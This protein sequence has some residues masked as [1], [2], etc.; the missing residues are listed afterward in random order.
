MSNTLSFT[1]KFTTD[2]EKATMITESKIQLLESLVN[3]ADKF[4][5][6]APYWN[7]FKM[8]LSASISWS[9]FSLGC[10]VSTYIDDKTK[11]LTIEAFVL[12]FLLAI[13]IIGIFTCAYIIYT[14]K[15]LKI[16]LTF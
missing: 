9:L 5:K 15:E 8:G 4:E 13:G 2:G 10:I 14:E 16:N 12:Y 3:R 11:L 6:T 1:T 7:K